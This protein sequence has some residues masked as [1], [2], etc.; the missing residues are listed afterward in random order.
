[1]NRDAYELADLGLTDEEREAIQLAVATVRL[2]GDAGGLALLKLGGDTAGE[3]G[4][5][6][7]ALPSS[8]S[9]PTLF[10]ANATRTPVR[11]SYRGRVRTV[12]PYGLLTRDGFWYVVGYEHESGLRKTFRVDRIDGEA[13]LDTGAEA[14]V[15]PADFDPV[16]AVFTDPKRLAEE[17]A[18][19]VDALVAVDSLRAASVVREVGAASVIE[20]R[21]DGGVVVKVPAT[22][23]AAFRSWVLGLLDHAEV[24][25]PPEVRSELVGWLEQVAERSG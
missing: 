6:L 10:E 17:G 20:R 15:A 4:P 14:F 11:F 13:V 5:L 19:P 22:N 21:A 2:G 8:S 25:A 16:A 7:A 3:A 23:R 1:M 9:L 12:D 24:V 18:E